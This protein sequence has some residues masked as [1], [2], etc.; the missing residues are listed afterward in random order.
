MMIIMMLMQILKIIT[1]DTIVIHYFFAPPWWNNFKRTH[2]FHN[3]PSN[4]TS[5]H[6]DEKNLNNK[7][8]SLDEDLK[9]CVVR[10]NDTLC[11]EAVVMPEQILIKTCR[12]KNI[13]KKRN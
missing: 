2:H 1:I 5:N 7:I 3:Y 4:D 12:V 10:D 11:D 13:G 8:P 9:L 6:D